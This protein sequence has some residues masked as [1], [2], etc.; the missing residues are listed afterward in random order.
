MQIFR[1]PFK[2]KA[3]MLLPVLLMA[4]A[5]FPADAEGADRVPTERMAGFHETMV[6]FDEICPNAGVLTY[7]EDR[8]THTDQYLV[9]KLVPCLAGQKGPVGPE[10][11]QDVRVEDFAGGV[12]ASFLLEGVRVFVEL[13]PLPAGRAT[14]EQDGAAI[15]RIRT[16]PATPIVLRCGGGRIYTFHTPQKI[17]REKGFKGG[18]TTVQIDGNVGLLTSA[19]QPH[20][21][22]VRSSGTLSV[23]EGLE[24]EAILEIL[25]EEGRGTALIAFGT[26]AAGAKR[27]LEQN[28]RADRDDVTVYYDELL[29]SR[30]ETPEKVLDQCFRSAVYNLEYN[31]IQPFGWTE[32]IHHWVSMFHMQHTGG[33]EWLGQEDRSR[34]CTL[35]QAERIH[36]DGRI[37]LLWPFGGR[38]AAF[39]GTNQ[40]FA[41]QIRHYWKFTADR[42]FIEQA[43]PALN[44]AI[45]QTFREYD[46][47]GDLLLSWRAQIGNQEDYLHHPHNSAGPSIEGINMMRTAAMLAE[48]LGDESSVGE[49]D[50]KIA[51]AQTNLVDELWSSELGRFLYY[52]DPQG[53]KHLDGQYQ[54]FIYPLIWD[55]VDPLDAWTG[56]RHLRDRLSGPGGE[57]Y[58]SNNFPNHVSGTWGMQAGAAQQPW[59]AFGLSAMGLR[60]ET[61]LPLRAL[62][63]WV[64]SESLR[65]SW[66]EISLEP[67]PAYFSPPAGLF[68]QAV[69]EALFGLNMD[70]P[71][72]VLEIAPSF[73]DHW[74]SARL[75]LPD[76]RAEYSRSSGTLEYMLESREPLARHLRWL[77]PPCR[78]TELAVDGKPAG[79][80]I[81]PAVGCV[82]L[83]CDIPKSKRSRITVR[84]EPLDFSVSHPASIAE[85]DTLELTTR[86]C[87]VVAVD[88]RCGVLRDHRLLSGSRLKATIKRGLLK[89]FLEYGRL[90]QLNFSRRTFF[91]FCDAGQGVTFWHPV[92]VALLPAH[93]IAPRG[94][95]QP[96]ER[97]GRVTVLVRNNSF[98]PLQG[99]AV[100]M[101]ARSR[102]RVDVDVAARSEETL[103]V[104][105]PKPY[106]ALLSPGDNACSVILPGGEKHAITLTASRLFEEVAPLKALAARRLSRIPLPED[107]FVDHEKWFSF[108]KLHAYHH[109]PWAWNKSPL[110]DL[111]PGDLLSAPE[112]PAV[113]FELKR[114]AV[115]PVSYRFGRPSVRVNLQA[116]SFKKLYLLVVP[117]LDSHNMFAPV[118]H[119]TLERKDRRFIG[120]TLHFP[121]DLDWW[122]PSGLLGDFATCRRGPRDRFGILPLLGPEDS[123]WVEG[124]PDC[125]I[126]WAWTR[127][128]SDMKFPQPEFWA[129]CL[130][131]ENP[132]SVMSIIE[133]DLG[134]ATALNGLTLSTIGLEPCLGLVAIVGEEPGGMG[135]LVGTEWMPPDEF[136]EPA[137]V[138]LLDGTDSLEGWTLE[139]TAFGAAPVPHLFDE[140]T[141]NSL[142]RAGEK[143]TGRAISPDFVLT[144]PYAA[145]TYDLQGGNATS[146][147]GPGLLTIDLV[148][149]KSGERLDRRLIRGSHVLRRETILIDQSWRG[150]TV[151]LELI[152]RNTDKSYAW[153][154]LRRVSLSLR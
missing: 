41:W 140:A 9:A 39:G 129:T 116:K 112:L 47:E 13:F 125:R 51:K 50:A 24:D 49:Y 26:S 18:Q 109:P 117:F 131:I 27:M 61:F 16:E 111:K 19:K 53:T 3:V 85:G 128:E 54:T 98:E 148:D 142:A 101:A 127:G 74:P 118:A 7:V 107:L 4:A 143:A 78:V 86:G 32:C 23:L 38:Y 34:S 17:I 20:P 67:T 95:V 88:D 75:E 122:C 99:E 79:F 105:I 44:A 11:A 43:A 89:P 37:P 123:D 14:D 115:I 90:G 103:E 59:G 114:L 69:V 28:A 83:S 91:L 80:K 72:G 87:T 62:S 104:S 130:P 154:G 77:L 55:L 12:E 1:A 136:A 71:A 124:K 147:E 33:V 64:M 25:F 108:R 15:Y 29:K 150:R 42:A 92:D 57:V 70:R 146:E 66:P 36:D 45:A 56:M 139:G 82:L 97:G 152:D 137:E 68:V 63:K 8:G 48:V 22:A 93:E 145:L 119:I 30:I 135:T 102:F 40:Y 100:L 110:L 35:S 65:G 133:I 151:H 52:K 73:P 84:F 60:N 94:E 46:P 153:L 2:A 144:G 126:A 10:K 31:W 120:R 149:S 134:E 106:L 21:V 6:I 76:Y 58:C 5:F 132:C 141:L 121:G 81:S 96:D 138:F 113:A